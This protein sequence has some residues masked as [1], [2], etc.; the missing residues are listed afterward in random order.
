MFTNQNFVFQFYRLYYMGFSKSLGWV[1]EASAAAKPPFEEKLVSITFPSAVSRIMGRTYTTFT[2]FHPD[3][4]WFF[5][6]QSHRFFVHLKKSGGGSSMDTR[7]CGPRPRARWQ[8]AIH[9]PQANQHCASSDGFMGPEKLPIFK[10]RSFPDF[11]CQPL[12]PNS[13]LLW[14]TALT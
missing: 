10:N 5:F 2:M 7:L 3:T 12:T 14:A 13:G 11:F 8:R 9:I 6:K 1:V 4:T